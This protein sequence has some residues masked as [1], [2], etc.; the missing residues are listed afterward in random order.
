MLLTNWLR[1]IANRCRSK[2]PRRTRQPKRVRRLSAASLSHA[3]STRESIAQ[4]EVLEDRT[5]LTS[6]FSISSDL[7][8][9]EGDSGD[10]IAT[11]TITRTGSYTGSL[12]S[13]ATVDFHTEDDTALSSEGDY[14]PVSTTVTFGADS[15]SLKQTQTVEVII[16]GDILVEEEEKFK[17]ILSNNSSGTTIRTSTADERIANDDQARISIN[18]VTVNEADGTAVLTVSM[19]KPVDY[20]YVNVG[21]STSPGTA[22]EG[23][24]SSDYIKSTGWITFSS[25]EQSKTI[26][27]NINDDDLFEFE[28]TFNVNL[29]S[30]PAYGLDIIIVDDRGVVTIEPDD[31]FVPQF[32]LQSKLFAPGTANSYDEYGGSFAVDDDTMIV[33]SSG[34]DEAGVNEGAAFIYTRNNQGTPTD[35][36]DDTWDYQ[37][38]L[39]P[40][41][42]YI[43]DG[44]GSS[45]TISGNT[46]VVADYLDDADTDTVNSGA[47]YVYTRSNNVWTF[48]QKLTPSDPGNS[49]WFGRTMIIKNNTIIV[50]VPK[51]EGELLSGT[52]NPY[53]DRDQGAVYI[54]TC[55]GNTWSETARLTASDPMTNK[56][57][58]ASIALEGSTLVIGAPRDNEIRSDS[59]AV[60]VF[61]LQDGDWIEIQKLK[62]SSPQDAEFFGNSVALDG[63]NLVVGASYHESL[64][65]D[66]D[67]L[68]NTGAAYV[69][70]RVDD[71]WQE[72]QM[73]TI[74]PDVFNSYFGT[75]VDIQGDLILVG[76]TRDPASHLITDNGATY[77]FRKENSEW[78]QVDIL[79]DL[80][81]NNHA[82]Y[83]RKIAISHDL[84]MI[85][86]VHDNAQEIAA[87]SIYVYRP[88]DLPIISID[89][90][91]FTEGDT[92]S[93]Y[94]SIEV[95][96]TSTTPG[97]LS[98]PAL[99][100]FTT[101]DGD[102][103]VMTGDYLGNSGTLSFEGDPD[104]VSQ[105]RTF[106]V[107][108]FGDTFVE[109]NETFLVK[110]SNPL[111]N[112][113]LL[114]KTATIT[115]TG[116]DQSL[117]RIDDVS[118]HEN[119]G[120][121]TIFVSLDKPVDATVSVDY[122]TA[123]RTAYSTA[124]YVSSSGTIT[125]TAGT[126][127]Q[128]ITIPIVDNSQVE[129]EE[130]FY[131]NLSHIQSEGANVAFSD[132]QGEV[133]IQD[134]DQTVIPL[135]SIDDVTVNEEAGTATLNVSLSAAI[136]TTVT[137]DYITAN[138]TAVSPNDYLARSGT[139]TFNPL[140]TAR[141][142]TIPIF[143]SDTVEADET[144]FV[145]LDNIQSGVY[146]VLM[147]DDQALVTIL[148]K[149]RPRLTI[150]DLSVNE[151][152]G[153]ATLSV[154]LTKA[155]T[156]AVSIEY[157]TADESAYSTTDFG[158]STGIVTF[159]TG[160]TTQTIEIPLTDDDLV[161][162]DESFLVNLFNL[163]DGSLNVS[164][165]DDQARVT[166]R[167]DD[168]ATISIDDLTVNEDA[169][170]AVLQV[171]LSAP[172]DGD[173][174]VDFTTADQTA[175]SPDD[176]AET[177]G[178]LQ[179]H[180]GEQLKTI[181]VPIVNSTPLEAY[182]SFLVNLSH[183]QADGLIV[184]IADNQ[185]EVTIIDSIPL[186]L[187][188]DDVTV[189]EAGGTATLSVSL[190]QA[191]NSPF[192]VDFHTDSQTALPTSDYTDTSG[193][194][195]FASQ[196]TTKTI[197]IPLANDD[198]AEPD[199]TFL[200]SLENIQSTDYL[201]EFEDDQAV[202]TIEDDDQP[203]LSI[204]DLYVNETAGTATVTVSLSKQH[205]QAFSVDYATSDGSA[206]AGLDYQAT[207]GT[208]YFASNQIS[209]TIQIPIIDDLLVETYEYFKVTLSNLQ[210]GSLGVIL[211][212]R[213]ANVWIRPDDQ[214][215]VSISDLTVNEEDGT[216]LVTVSLDRKVAATVFVDYT[217]EDESATSGED[218]L[219]TAGRVTFNPEETTQTIEI[220]LV[221]SSLPE[222]TE[223]FAVKISQISVS[224]GGYDVIIGDG[225]ASV[226]ILDQGLQSIFSIA[227]TS[228]LEGADGTQSMTFEVT[229]T[230]AA[231]GDLDF[232][233][234]V[235]FS[236]LDGTAVA[237]I[238]YT[239][240]STTLTFAADSTATTQTQTVTIEVQGDLII[241]DSETVIGRLSNPTGVSILA[242]D[243]STLDATGE[244]TNDDL[245]ENN[246]E[247]QAPYYPEDINANHTGY[248]TG[249]SIAIDGNYMVVGDVEKNAIYVYVRNDHGTTED[250]SD[251]TWEFQTELNPTSSSYDKGFGNSVAISGNVIVTGAY[252]EGRGAVYVFE[253][254]GY[255]WV[256][257]APFAKLVTLGSLSNYSDFGYSVALEGNSTLVVGAPGVSGGGAV[258]IIKP[259]AGSWT[260]PLVREIRPDGL[261]AGD[262]FGHSVAIEGDLLVV[263]AYGDDENGQTSG[264]AYVYSKSDSSWITSSIYET[265]L[266]ASD[267]EIYDEFGGAVATNG[268]AVLVGAI[269]GGAY[270]YES[271]GFR[272]NSY[273]PYET[274]FIPHLETPSSSIFGYSVAISTTGLLIGAPGVRLPENQNA[275]TGAAFYY[276]FAGYWSNSS[277]KQRVISVETQDREYF[278]SAVALDGTTI[279]VGAIY[280]D[281]DGID[282]GGT[283]VFYGPDYTN[284][285]LGEF[286]LTS[287]LPPGP[288]NKSN[289]EDYYGH[290]LAMNDDYLIV[291]APGTDSVLAPGGGVYIYAKDDHGT[292]DLDSDDS[293]IYQ[294][295]LAGPNPEELTLFGSSVAIYGNTIVVGSYSK[296]GQYEVFIYE[297]NGSDWTTTAPTVTSLFDSVSRTVNIDLDNTYEDLIAFSG[298]TIVVGNPEGDGVEANSGVVY[299]YTRNGADWSTAAPE[300]SV[301]YASDGATDRE[302]GAAV[303]IDG[304]TI[305]VGTPGWGFG[306]TVYVYEKQTDWDHAV[307]TSLLNPLLYYGIDLYGSAVAIS[308]DT[309]FVGSPRSIEQ[310]ADSGAVF[311]IDGSMGWENAET[312]KY[313]ADEWDNYRGY[314][315]SLFAVDN[316]LIV[317]TTFGPTYIYDGSAGWDTQNESTVYSPTFSLGGSY[318]PTQRIAYYGN[319]L[320]AYDVIPSFQPLPEDEQK[321]VTRINAFTRLVP[322]FTIDNAE[323][324][325][326]DTGTQTL[327][328]TVTL[329][330]LTSDLYDQTI[331]IDYTT[332]DGTATAASGDYQSQTGTLSFNLTAGTETQT[333]TISIPINGD[334][335]IETDEFFKVLLRNPSI[336]ALVPREI[337]TAT[338]RDNDAALL[339]ISDTTVNE[340]EGTATLTLTLDREIAYP[341]TVNYYFQSGTAGSVSDFQLVNGS[342]TFDEGDLSKTF[343]V[344]IVDNA[345]VEFDETFSVNIVADASPFDVQYSNSTATIT[346]VDDDQAQ[347]SIDDIS[348]DEET[349]F[350]TVTVSLDQPVDGTVTLDYATA[351][352]TALADA[353]YQAT[354]GTLT[355][356]ADEQSKTITINLVNSDLIEVDKTFLVNLTNLQSNGLDVIMPDN[357]AEVTIT[358]SDLLHR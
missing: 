353:D 240:L 281:M 340:G 269:R 246:F 99:V 243:V 348:V 276:E 154:N 101:L 5:L 104:A 93:K 68:D 94:V 95:T 82:Y 279:A 132:S 29:N 111:G 174:F 110:L 259:Q 216:A 307:E 352:Q 79:R 78:V 142:I 136:P 310:K 227:P 317:T 226:T 88:A 30:L 63:D 37:A 342:V 175:T 192:S 271:N 277:L 181:T 198:V 42:G 122:T 280:A 236:T 266:T 158:S 32:D 51:A 24:S 185:A 38:T 258:Y 44:F 238:D 117:V 153:T 231:P 225:R 144:F 72:T 309:I 86:A 286:P 275:T 109:K 102:A 253:R 133:S 349:G 330:G 106:T 53:S 60:Y 126:Q 230:G 318:R 321:R 148:D 237:G 50:G 169:G 262:Q 346:I 182:R 4:T 58:G 33:G 335:T 303:D 121:A 187:S 179:F 239:A 56:N 274:K 322:T 197:T 155:Q 208:L 260:N 139:V 214:A 100:N 113:R 41:A 202:V 128:F 268:Y 207:S 294:T 97:D 120:T 146:Q 229:R 205:P 81:L 333:R 199:E 83:G 264:A 149:D 39:L 311:I 186:R 12:N 323:I 233:S 250:Q 143:D 273:G 300:E 73:L 206:D 129:A 75:A 267:G 170:T 77:I 255:G 211:P 313:I 135:L 103:K 123:N 235:D 59:G 308:G 105:T 21:Y 98:I 332:L 296:S 218:Y 157:A 345:E 165:L 34:W 173:V 177:T 283:Y 301:L 137:V 45:V 147:N 125:F 297:M 265:R 66:T 285:S 48:Q 203:L 263:G 355:F 305:V 299:V 54:Y 223:S 163:Q 248:E 1:S 326:G 145:F 328:L 351:D 46:A 62:P 7:R 244:I 80:D 35:Y 210:T 92:G 10:T 217:T 228:V 107:Q 96:R 138:D 222:D 331:T 9:D 84:I 315:T 64:N 31:D 188:I 298:D 57:F 40:P 15:T 302:F 251:D 14:V 191:I 76:S 74:T 215:N 247:F 200:V 242:G 87:G 325:E 288:L 220:P 257:Y 336:K 167:D 343:T 13:V 189:N 282:S 314:G 284:S 17:G 354:S 108:I 291:G 140:E 249:N 70:T 261:S 28:E 65:P 91:S 69:F 131:V 160:E 357:Q 194:L 224:S 16:N 85:N 295:I 156:E 168:Q 347:V 67:Q 112:A 23:Y 150:S 115:I 164:L 52:S 55:S 306:W 219:A 278:G 2:Y 270:L 176:Y 241:E 293:W 337:A 232:E 356:T 43:T 320:M 290:T 26:T 339:N 234:S 212:S 312:I 61:E 196:Q 350:A 190:N 166:I 329:G 6:E 151:G 159:A 195:V 22:T 292:P 324:V 178:T 162:A 171:S 3:L 201:V 141:T 89:N 184:T 116:D 193:T 130:S 49:N 213:P 252:D 25:G 209:K 338:I 272:A 71:V 287:E 36:S 118:V 47:I 316:T 18:D 304:D 134:D 245:L 27:V 256:T 341:F 20:P 90:M 319:Y 161:E 254:L 327:D 334:E 127:S 221:D 172:V 11:F 19:D 289:V 344:P 358:D 124:D 152:A 114:D 183:V 180:A 8:I 204:S 119:D